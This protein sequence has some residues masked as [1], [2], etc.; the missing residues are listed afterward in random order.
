MP[1]SRWCLVAGV[2]IGFGGELGFLQLHVR[3]HLVLRVAARQL[4]HA[5]VQRV[6]AGQGD[7]LEL[8]AHGA[9]FALEFGDGGVIQVGFPVEAR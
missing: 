4:V 7:E 5:V 1:T 8:V 2:A 6:E 9:Q 3:G